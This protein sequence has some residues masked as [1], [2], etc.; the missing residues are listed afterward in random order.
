MGCTEAS[1]TILETINRIIARG[2]KV[3]VCY[4]DM[5]KAFDTIWIEGLLFKLFCD[6]VID[7]KF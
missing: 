6:L 1:F 4:L 5:K 7:D 3:F 2:G